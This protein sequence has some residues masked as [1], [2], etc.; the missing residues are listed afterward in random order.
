MTPC[1]SNGQPSS[2]SGRVSRPLLD[3]LRSPLVAVERAIRDAGSE[4]QLREFGVV[5]SVQS[6]IARVAGL[7]RV[8]REEML[9]FQ[10]GENG[11]AFNLDPDDIGVV[12]LDPE[13]GVEAGQE[14]RRLGRELE[15][16]VGEE[17]LGRIVDGRGRPVDEQGPVRGARDRPAERTAPAILSRV[18]VAEP[19]QTG[20]KVVDALVPIG[21]GQRELIVGDRQTGKTTLAVDALVH[22]ATSGMVCVYCAVG[23]RSSAVARVVDRL[24]SSGALENTVV[25]VAGG[26]VPPGLQYM[27]PYT[28]TTVAEH[29]MEGGQDVLVVYDDLVRHARAFRELSLLLRRPPGREAYPGDIFHIHARLLERATRL[30]EEEG[31]GSLTALPVVETEAQNIA[32]YIPTNLIS[33]TDGQIYLSPDLFQRGVLPAVDVERSVSRVGGQAQLPAYR[34]VVG[35]LKLAYAQ[36]L[37]LEIF[38]RFATQLDEETRRTLE[39][40]RRVREVL[41]QPEGRPLSPAEQVAVLLAVTGGVL[42]DVPG[43]DVSRVESRIRDAVRTRLPDLCDH[44]EAGE[45]LVPSDVQRLREVARRALDL[46]PAADT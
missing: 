27:A 36:F 11:L 41:K 17:L 37:E 32:A 5:R 46:E 31:G 10:G 3:V 7:S 9:R 4:P 26:D 20:V 19:L 13:D 6:G 18:P 35:D 21:R 44:I 39:R 25:V 43:D 33:I 8:G 45:E 38:S 2:W 12:L 40:G 16:P 42:D 34:S 1:P 29:F 23:Q 28:A 24:R 30:R 14:V 15:V 22:Q